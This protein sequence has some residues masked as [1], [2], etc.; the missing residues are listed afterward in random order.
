MIAK[1]QWDE[2]TKPGQTKDIRPKV[3]GKTKGEKSNG[4]D[5]FWVFFRKTEGEREKIGE[6]RLDWEVE[7]DEK[8]RK[9]GGRLFHKAGAVRWKD[10]LVI[11]RR[12][13]IIR[14]IKFDQRSR[15]CRRIM[16]KTKKGMKI[17]RMTRV[18]SFISE[19]F[20]LN[21]LIKPDTAVAFHGLQPCQV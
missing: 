6:F 12:V 7:L 11:L 9:S 5:E 15:A 21:S 1:W 10:L 14:T 2:V 17:W 13:F 8:W 16:V 4:K 3:K 20:V 19:N 18:K